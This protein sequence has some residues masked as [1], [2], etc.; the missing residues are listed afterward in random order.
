MEMGA[1]QLNMRLLCSEARLSA[2]S[3][4]EGYFSES[5][6]QTLKE[7][8]A[9]MTSLPILI[10]DT[11]GLTLVQL[12]SRAR[13]L[14]AQR[15]DLGLIVVDYLQLMSAPAGRRE[16]NRQQEV[17]EISRGLKILA[18]ELRV[19]VLALSQLSRNIE[20][21]GTKKEP[22][23]P[24][25]SDL[26]ESGSI[27]QDADIVMFIHRERL[28]ITGEKD[29]VPVDRRAPIPSKIIVAKNRNGP[30]G[31]AEMLFFPDYTRF[32]NLMG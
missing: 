16:S 13:R 17:A 5:Q 2:H 8:A 21:R 3:I 32:G 23:V 12:R 20:Q 18:K 14:K 7:T 10:D 4:K 30:T 22:A 19:P 6:F 31:A 29:G 27:E 15:P 1:E 26:R 28:E 9:R 24:M 25:L 11:A